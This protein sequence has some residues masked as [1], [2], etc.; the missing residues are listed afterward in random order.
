MS[1]PRTVAVVTVARSDYGHLCPVLAALRDAPDVH[2][3]LFVAGAHLVP[4]LGL[5]VREIEADGWLIAASVD[6]LEPDDSP[7]GVAA[8]TGRAIQGFARAYAKHHPDLVVV[9]GDRIE[10]LAAAAAAL[11]F[12]LPVAHIHG[13]EVTE[14]AMDNQIRHAI[15]K[16]AHLHFVSAPVHAERLVRMDEE[17]WRI[18]TVGAPGLDRLRSRP[19]LSRGDLAGRLGLPAAG[20]WII[21]T[22]HP[23][24]LEYG[25][26]AQH[27]A[28][29]I[30]ALETIPGT[31][32]VTYPGADTARRT[33]IDALEAF[34]RR[35]TRVRLQPSL[36][37]LPY[38][39]LLE[40]A[41]VMVGN[42]S[43]GLIEAP[44]FGLPVVNI[45]HRQ[46]G[47]LR[48]ANVID[49]G[50]GRDEIRRGIAAALT[51][52]LRDRLRTSPNPYGDGRAAPRIVEILRRV[53]LD[54]ALVQKRSTY[55]EDAPVTATSRASTRGARRGPVR[56]RRQDRD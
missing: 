56:P 29:L 49:V 26:T 27:V 41:D 2:P 11:P 18:Y 19:F 6:V 10:M 55:V 47:R 38:L 32:V 39:S 50:Y 25:D 8:A 9:L 3:L 52:G 1:T 53:P 22:Y 23:V 33:I 21:V 36:G 4:E 20:P 42:S 37:E 34:A 17:R 44:T 35:S 45:G 30:A 46:G 14:G 48:G 43:S 7:A 31:F 5:S 24:T 13:G 40:H 15:S 28:E 51:P 12:A 54:A 16:L